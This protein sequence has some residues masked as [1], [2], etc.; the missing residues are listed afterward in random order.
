MTKQGLPDG[1]NL[2]KAPYHHLQHSL[3]DAVVDGFQKT[4]KSIPAL[5]F[6]D[7]AGSQLFEQICKLPE[8]YP[9]RT[10]HKILRGNV[11]DIISI[12][13]GEVELVELGSGSSAKTRILIDAILANQTHLQYIPTD[14]STDF[15]LESS[16]TL[17]NEYERLSITA[18]AAEHSDA[19]QL[20][21]EGGSQSRLFLFLGSNIGNSEPEAAISFI[22]Q[23]R[24]RMRA[25]DRL[26]I[27][28]DL[29]KDRQV[30]FDAYNDKAGI[31]AE[32]NKNLLVRINRELGGDF[33]VNRF[34]HHAPFVEGH[35]RVEMHL[36]SRCAQAVYLERLGQRFD[37]EDG[38]YI[39]TE[40]S[41][42]YTLDGFES[43]CQAAGMN[44]Q[45][46][47]LDERE[48]FAVGLCRGTS[49]G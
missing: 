28:F 11:R 17:K 40:N 8:Y 46:Y 47:W 1:L 15:L 29:V 7:T 18:I 6:Y 41:Y 34:D 3:K 45:E 43:L 38:E 22:G 48:W 16:V 2:I 19:L 30:L 20:L 37:F 39:H 26:L 25:E 27:G 33:D 14:I 32:F 31:T 10:E 13:T 21:P 44:M 36:I 5:F 42:K 9:T 24:R 4:P 23:I 12:V 49:G 35:S